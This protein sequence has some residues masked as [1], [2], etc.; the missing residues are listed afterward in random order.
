MARTDYLGEFEEIVLLAVA[1]L[2]DDGYGMR[3]RREIE[4]RTG[5]SVSIGAVYATLERLADK[6]FVRMGQPPSPDG[7]GRARRFFRMTP[8]GSAA[9]AN[10]E[11]ARASLRAG[12]KFKRATRT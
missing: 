7:D 6:G 2:G 3:V 10:A 8:V 5:R 11:A 1:R 9:L 12:L 4:S